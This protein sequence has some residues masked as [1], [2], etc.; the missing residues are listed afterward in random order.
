MKLVWNKTGDHIICEPV[1]QEFAN[2]WLSEFKE[3]TWNVNSTLSQHISL[4]YLK[5]LLES[6]QSC[7]DRLKL[8]LYSSDIECIDQNFL[9][10]IHR[11]WVIIHQKYPNI[12][13][14]FD[15]K[16]KDDMN[17]INKI[18]HEI[19]ESWQ[20]NLETKHILQNVG[21]VPNMFGKSNLM[22]PYENLGRSNY[23]KW[24]NFD[25]IVDTLDT[26]D[27]REIYGKLN[28]NLN[29]HFVSF[30]PIEYVQWAG[31]NKLSVKPNVLLLA[32]FKELE[33][34]LYRYRKLFLDNFVLEQ[35]DVIFTT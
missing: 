10:E 23:N 13:R 6:V 12:Y 4:S 33:K 26:N 20:V 18:I 15:N 28:F 24:L 25:N 9:N 30:P 22:I 21:N 16:F 35:N 19:E 11:N 27:F 8:L 14:L 34:N 32:N 29:R 3:L 7:L 5:D 31:N 17:K 1:D 2:Y